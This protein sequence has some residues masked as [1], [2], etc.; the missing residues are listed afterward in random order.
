MG[1]WNTPDVLYLLFDV[2]SWVF[3]WEAVDQFFLQRY[4][5]KVKQHKQIQLIYAKITFKALRHK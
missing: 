4:F 1:V 2:F 3:A 5:L